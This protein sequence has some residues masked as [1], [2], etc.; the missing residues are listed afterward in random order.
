M[1]CYA[2]YLLLIFLLTATG[3]ASAQFDLWEIYTPY[4]FQKHKVRAIN[5]YES[6]DG[7]MPSNATMK[8]EFDTLGRVTNSTGY[9]DAGDKVDYVLQKVYRNSD[10]IVDTLFLTT[11]GYKN[12]RYYREMIKSSRKRCKFIE[13][14]S[15][16]SKNTILCNYNRDGLVISQE[17]SSHHDPFVVRTEYQYHN[18]YMLKKRVKKYYNIVATMSI[19]LDA[20][21]FLSD[22]SIT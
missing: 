21:G 15:S 1:P 5:F 19:G 6:N 11:N 12:R 20:R 9:N 4:F 22:C 17:D 8:I 14:K 16:W 13:H 18:E 10:F 2:R 3:S 7:K